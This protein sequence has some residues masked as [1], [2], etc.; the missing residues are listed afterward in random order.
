MEQEN[1]TLTRAEY[2]DFIQM[3]NQLNQRKNVLLMFQFLGCLHMTTFNDALRTIVNGNKPAG[4]PDVALPPF[5][6]DIF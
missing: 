6:L 2:E 3:R 5:A 4:R 1:I